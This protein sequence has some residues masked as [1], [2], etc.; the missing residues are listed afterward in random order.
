MKLSS[1]VVFKE[2]NENVVYALFLENENDEY[3]KFE[4]V[5]AKALKFASTQKSFEKEDI[6]NFILSTYSDAEKSQVEEDVK[7]LLDFFKDQGF[8]S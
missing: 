2:V 7:K 4:G 1:S 3:F 5:S 6:V 8:L